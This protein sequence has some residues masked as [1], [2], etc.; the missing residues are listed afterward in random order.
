MMLGMDDV[1]IALLRDFQ[2]F[3]NGEGVDS[4]LWWLYQLNNSTSTVP[5][6][7]ARDGSRSRSCASRP[8]GAK[9]P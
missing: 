9:L 7:S 3:A 4:P 2:P 5:C 6:T 8:C 1:T